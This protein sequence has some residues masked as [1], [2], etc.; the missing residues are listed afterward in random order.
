MLT[1]V[2]VIVMRKL[3]LS[4]EGLFRIEMLFRMGRMRR[5]NLSLMFFRH[6]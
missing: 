1:M 5:Y 4:F 3:L 2:A 6:F